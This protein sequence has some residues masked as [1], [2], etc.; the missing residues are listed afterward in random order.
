[1]H[2]ALDTRPENETKNFEV[3]NIYFPLETQAMKMPTKGS[4]H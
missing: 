1:M 4:A 3:K 2:T